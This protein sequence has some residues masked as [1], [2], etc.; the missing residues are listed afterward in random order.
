MTVWCFC[1]LSA[2][3]NTESLIVDFCTS[4]SWKWSQIIFYINASEM[5][6]WPK[7][8][9]IRKP[10]CCDI[11]TGGHRHMGQTADVCVCSFTH[12][13]R[14]VCHVHNTH[15]YSHTV[16]ILAALF[17]VKAQWHSLLSLI[18]QHTHV[19]PVCFALCSV[20]PPRFS[21]LLSTIHSQ[22]P[23]QSQH[24]PLPRRMLPHQSIQ[25]KIKT[26]AGWL[27]DQQIKKCFSALISVTLNR[28][29]RSG[30]GAKLQG[31]GLNAVGGGF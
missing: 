2:E 11:V 8:P 23:E 17:A 4:T 20:N 21:S 7:N 5:R 9:Q 15:A 31:V 28:S 26:Q 6:T 14:P 13:T 18:N 30:G 27:T 24:A 3:N 19:W 12:K 1:C 22:M 16:H 25:S 29:Q 10:E